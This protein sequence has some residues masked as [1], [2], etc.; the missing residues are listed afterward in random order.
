M[1]FIVPFATRTANSDHCVLLKQVSE[2]SKFPFSCFFL[3]TLVLTS[4][5]D[6]VGK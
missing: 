5:Y 6:V 1:Y 4:F 3:F 2:I